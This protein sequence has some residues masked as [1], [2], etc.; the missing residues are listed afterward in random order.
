MAIHSSTIAWKIPWTEEPG[1]LH[2]VHGVA[3]SRTRLSDF[4]SLH[5]PRQASLVAQTVK[6]LPAMQETW[7]RSLDWEDSLEKGVATHSSILAWRVPWTE[8]PGGQHSMGSQRV[9]QD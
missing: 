6:N 8:E 1:R 2:V 9:R 5:A 3:K 4:T 7:V